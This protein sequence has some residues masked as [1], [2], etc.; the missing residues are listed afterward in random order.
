MRK[1][2]ISIKLTVRMYKAIVDLAVRVI[3]ALTGNIGYT[4][5]LPPL[6]SLQTAADDVTAAIAKW[7]DKKNRGSHSDLLDLQ[8]KARL[9]LDM[10]KAESQYVMNTAQATMGLDYVSMGNMI[11]TS[12]FGQANTPNPQGIL[13]K[14][15]NLHQFLSRQLNRNQV[16][17]KWKRPLNVFTRGNIKEYRVLRAENSTDISTAVE[18]AITS[19]SS[20]TDVNTSNTVKV[21]TYWVLAYNDTAGIVSDALT[22][23]VLGVI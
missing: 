13:E 9:L 5:P 22:I 11:G 21:W 1:P 14:V 8:M 18:V 16:K 23:A 19:K 7:G 6:T 4:T 20:F 3:A 2:V 17:I 12:G 15:Q 10:L